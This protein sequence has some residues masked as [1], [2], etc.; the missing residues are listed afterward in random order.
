MGLRSTTRAVWCLLLILSV[1][2]PIRAAAAP[3][4]ERDRAA[5]FATLQVPNR[6]V[7]LTSDCRVYDPA[8]R[9]RSATSVFTLVR[10]DNPAVDPGHLAPAIDGRTAAFLRI[11]ASAGQRSPPIS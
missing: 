9:L 8:R 1:C 7:F 2:A 4:A 5:G 10:F 3:A 11:P 6:P